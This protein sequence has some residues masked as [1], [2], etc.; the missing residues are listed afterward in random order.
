MID[1]ASRLYAFWRITLPLAAPALLSVTLFAFTNAWNEFLFA[2]VF[3]TSESLRTLPIGLQSMVVGDILPWG[4][5][6]A[7]SLLTAIPVAVLYIY[8]QRYPGRRADRGC[9][10]GLSF[11]ATRGEGQRLHAFG[12]HIYGYPN[13]A[14]S[15]T[16]DGRRRGNT[17]PSLRGERQE[18]CCATTCAAPG[19]GGTRAHIACGGS[20]RYPDR[21]HPYLA[22]AGLMLLRDSSTSS[23]FL[24][25][26][27]IRR[28]NG[29]ASELRSL[30][31]H[32]RKLIGSGCPSFFSRVRQSIIAHAG[33][34][35]RAHLDSV[36]RRCAFRTSL[37][38]SLG[39]PG[40]SNG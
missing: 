10:E 31:P 14:G 8:A 24:P 2:F 9:G 15:R 18:G 38:R 7:A 17:P 21:S 13:Q 29:A 1:G 23:R 40:S 26:R 28:S 4:K 25:S 11:R 20:R 39:Y 32:C 19:T 27:S 35:G 22:L 30:P 16:R 36:R 5:L 33:L 6:M 37:S 12:R 34:S 3:I